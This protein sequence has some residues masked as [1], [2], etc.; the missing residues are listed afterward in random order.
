M[1][2]LRKR[3]LSKKEKWIKKLNKKK[4][5]EWRNRRRRPVYNI[6]EGVV[7]ASTLKRLYPKKEIEIKVC[8][9]F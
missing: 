3:A 4:K 8:A 9:I 7:E 1:G 5:N 6:E 2:G